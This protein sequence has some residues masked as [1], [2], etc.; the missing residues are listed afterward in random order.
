MFSHSFDSGLWPLIQQATIQLINKYHI[1]VRWMIKFAVQPISTLAC[2]NV[3]DT[4]RFIRT[5]WKAS[6]DH[7][8]HLCVRLDHRVLPHCCF[9]KMEQNSVLNQG[10]SSYFNFSFQHASTRW[11]KTRLLLKVL[12]LIL[13][14]LSNKEEFMNYGTNP[15]F[16]II[17]P[18]TGSEMQCIG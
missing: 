3:V 14:F 4:I 15:L 2:S 18:Q 7:I 9:Y 10:P 5:F 13:I 12:H 8:C 17:F 1:S 16:M 11:H 6:W